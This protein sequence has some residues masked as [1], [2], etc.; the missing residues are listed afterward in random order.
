MADERRD[1]S[2]IIRTYE[3]DGEKKNVYTK[4]G[5]AWVSEHG[6]KISIE[7]DVLPVSKDWNNKL[8]INKPYEKKEVQP[9]NEVLDTVVTDIPEDLSDIPF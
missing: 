5:T 7:L 2:A 1:V 6:S 4:V 9:P 8:Y 3:K